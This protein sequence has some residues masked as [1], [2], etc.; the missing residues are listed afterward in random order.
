MQ[1]DP[2][3]FATTFETPVGKLLLTK[4]CSDEYIA[5]ME[6]ATR[7]RHPAV[8]GIAD[9]LLRDFR[10]AVLEDRVKQMIGHMVKQ[11]M[12]VRGYEIAQQ[13]VKIEGIPFYAGTRYKAR[14][15]WTYHV[16]YDSSNRRSC[17]LTIDKAGGALPALATGKWVYWRSFSGWLRGAILFQ[18][19]PRE[20]Q[21][22]DAMRRDGYFAVQMP[23]LLRAV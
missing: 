5:A 20:D 2:G 18:E 4:L 13:K 7:L 11:I 9:L 8:T 3:S 15:E 1:Y 6:T 14:D 22:R 23:R 19:A 21:V 10:D 12:D 17:A 16:W